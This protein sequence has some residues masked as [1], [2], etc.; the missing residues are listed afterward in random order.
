MKTIPPGARMYYRNKLYGNGQGIVRAG[1]T[2]EPIP[3]KS[4]DQSYEE[5]PP[6]IWDIDGMRPALLCIEGGKVDVVN[7]S[8]VLPD[9]VA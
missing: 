6:E 9:N 4:Y 3:M 8:L 5:S 7:V 1:V 2:I